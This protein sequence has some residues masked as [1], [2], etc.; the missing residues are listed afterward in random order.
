[1]AADREALAPLAD[2]AV[3]PARESAD[4]QA[5]A[6]TLRLHRDPDGGLTDTARSIRDRARASVPAG[7]D[8]R[9][10][11]TAGAALDAGDASE[12]V[13]RIAMIVTAI[14][15]TVLLLL[16]YRSPVLWLLPLLCVGVA[17]LA[18]DAVCTR[19]AGTST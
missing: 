8:I 14:V 18:G 3:G 2:G 10:S 1:V 5:L 12:R 7:L 17:Y 19:W 16:T 6:L 15:V 4:G 13:A 11:G 9:F